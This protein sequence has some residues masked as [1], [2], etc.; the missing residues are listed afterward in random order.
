MSQKWAL[1]GALGLSP[2]TLHCENGLLVDSVPTMNGQWIGSNR[3]YQ[4]IYN[5]VTL[6]QGRADTSFSGTGTW[7]SPLSGGSLHVT[8][9][10][11]R[12][13]VRMTLRYDSSAT[14][15]FA[16][17]TAVLSSALTQVSGIEVFGAD[18][19]DSLFLQK[20]TDCAA[21]FPSFARSAGVSVRTGAQQVDVAR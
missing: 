2:L 10:L 3:Q 14:A 17:Y 15:R 21:V 1:L 16:S 20:C 8:G 5:G 7:E 4:L 12:G 19:T 9:V 13:T 18:S 11:A 6:T